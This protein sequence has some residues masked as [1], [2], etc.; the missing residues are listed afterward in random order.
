MSLILWAHLLENLLRS[1]SSA[2]D[3]EILRSNPSDVA[4]DFE[5][6]LTNHGTSDED[7]NYSLE[8]IS[9]NGFNEIE[10][11]VNL[12]SYP[13]AIFFF[14]NLLQTMCPKVLPIE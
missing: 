11:E 8:N 10:G 5:V 2:S 14:G 4:G 12:P 1:R 9:G 6:I 7:F 13:T 3:P